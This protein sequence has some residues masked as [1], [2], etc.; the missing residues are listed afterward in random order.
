MAVVVI[1][2]QHAAFDGHTLLG[3][4]RRQPIPDLDKP[5]ENEAERD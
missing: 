1:E 3:S 4:H 2:A 5:V